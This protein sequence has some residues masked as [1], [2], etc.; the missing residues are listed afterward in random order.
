MNLESQFQEN[1][2]K[3]PPEGQATSLPERNFT[4]MTLSVPLRNRKRKRDWEDEEEA[5]MTSHQLKR[6]RL[7]SGFDDQVNAGEIIDGCFNIGSRDWKSWSE[8]KSHP[9][10]TNWS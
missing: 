1:P 8:Q 7:E 9:E 5:A 3:L 10:V 2:F 4:T 6:L